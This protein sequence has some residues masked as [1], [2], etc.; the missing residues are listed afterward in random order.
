MS[1]KLTQLTEDT[2]PAITDITYG[3]KAPATAPLPR[4]LTWQ[5]ILNLFSATAETISGIKTFGAAGA[6]GKLKIAGNTSGS[7]ILDATAAAS[8]TLTLPA[9]TDTL[10]GKAT[11]D[12]LT[13]KALDAATVTTSLVPTTD[14][15]AALGSTS[16]RFSDLFLAEGGVINWDAGDATLTQVSDVVTLAGADLKVTTPGNAAT[17]V[18]TTDGTQTLTN[19]TLTA[20]AITDFTNM[21]HDHADADDGGLVTRAPL[22]LTLIGQFTGPA[23]STTHYWGFPTN[24]GSTTADARRVRI[25][26]AGTIVKAY[27]NVYNNSGTQGSSETFT[28]SI[29]LNNTTDITVTA[30]ATADAASG[31]AVFFA[32]GALSQ[33]V[34]EG[35][36]I[37]G[38]AVF[39][40]WATN[41][42]NVNMTL[43]VYI[44]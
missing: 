42:T 44:Q 17:S 4:K 3:V 35:D 14:D 31:A 18:V 32:S 6:V 30:S 43:L 34:V 26:A 16:K 33:A 15:A 8:G 24:T 1:K 5:T 7:T 2:N 40:A 23:D 29:R 39:P 10:V 20:P 28:V 13:N 9:A 22:Q 19:K 25:P 11:T 37:E 41:P 21:P 38:K 27:L 36:Y 12:I